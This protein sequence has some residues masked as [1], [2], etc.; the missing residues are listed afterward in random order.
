MEIDTIFFD[1]DSTLYPESC[2]LWQ[3]IRKRI[4]LYLH[5][6]MNFEPAEIPALRNDLFINHGTTLRGLQIHYDV[7]P[8]DYLNFVHDLPLHQYLRPDPTLRQI[9]S[10]IPYR[11]WVFTNADAAHAQRVMDI[12]GINDCFESIIDVWAMDPLCKPLEAVYTLALEKVGAP[13]PTSCALLDDSIRNLAP[14]HQMGF[15][16]ILVG[17]NGYHPV[18]DRSLADIHE[19]PRVVPEFFK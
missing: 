10:D 9:L 18:A 7:D 4:D 6:R 14:A 12:L 1:L 16:T 8:V 2:G 5:T 3:E 19:L 13:H 11:R 15:F 17:E